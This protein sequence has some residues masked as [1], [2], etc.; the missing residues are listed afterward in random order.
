MPSEILDCLGIH[1]C[2]NQIRNVSVPEL[3]R[4]NLEIKRIPL[5]KLFRLSGPREVLSGKE[6]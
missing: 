3:M 1:R 6:G 5:R 2:G 4:R